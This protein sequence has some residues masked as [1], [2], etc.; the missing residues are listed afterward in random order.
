MT[1]TQSRKDARARALT[2]SVATHLHATTDLDG[3]TFASRHGDDLALWA[4]FE[5]SGDPAIGHMLEAIEQHPLSPEIPTC[6]SFHD[7]RTDM[8][9]RRLTLR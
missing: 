8:V 6:R 9:R 1:S 2:Q 4:V 5:R 3:V 7:A